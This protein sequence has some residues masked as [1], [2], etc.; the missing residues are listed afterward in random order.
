MS[1]LMQRFVDSFFKGWE[2]GD[3]HLDREENRTIRREANEIAREK[4]RV[5]AQYNQWKMGDT[6][7][8]T[9]A[10]V[11]Q[12][13][14]NAQRLLA[15]AR[16]G[17]GASAGPSPGMLAYINKYG[18]AG[19]END[20]AP[21]NQNVTVEAN[22]GP[23]QLPN[24]GDGDGG[25]DTVDTGAARGGRI[26]RMAKGG[27]AN[28][29]A[30]SFNNAAAAGSRSYLAD[31]QREQPKVSPITRT[32]STQA[33]EGAGTTGPGSGYGDT[34][35]PPVVQPPAPVQP[36]PQAIE[37]IYAPGLPEQGGEY[38]R[39]GGRA[40]RHYAGGGPVT[41]DLSPEAIYSGMT[42]VG[43]DGRTVVLDDRNLK[44]TELLGTRSRPEVLAGV[45]TDEATQTRRIGNVDA[46]VGTR[47]IPRSTYSDQVGPGGGADVDPRQGGE[48]KY[49]PTV[50]PEDDYVNAPT[51][52]PT[53]PPTTVTAPRD[54][55]IKTGPPQW[56]KLR[57]QTRT[58]AYDP[59]KDRMDPH[60]TGP[61]REGRE[62]TGE[63]ALWAQSRPGGTPT[64]DP[65]VPGDKT[66][67]DRTPPG[68]VVY[69]QRVGQAAAQGATSFANRLFHQDRQDANTERGKAA[70]Y[71]GAGA[72]DPKAMQEVFK[73]IDP[74]NKLPMNQKIE[75][76]AQQVYDRFMQQGDQKA[77][78]NAAFEVTQFGIKMSTK[79]GSD[80]MKLIQQGNVAGAVGH[81][82][83]GYNW[84]PN[85]Q[86]AEQRGSNIVLVN[87]QGQVT[88]QFPLDPKMIQNIALGMSTGQLGWDVMQQAGGGGRQTAQAQQPAQP[89]PPAASGAQPSAAPAGPPQ[90]PAAPP[91]TPPATPP[92]APPAAA[93]PPPAAQPAA[94][95]APR[96]P[97]PPA[98]PPAGAPPAAP[99]ASPAPPKPT[100][101]PPATPPA[102]PPAKA[103]AG[104]GA[105]AP[106]TTPSSSTPATQ[107]SGAGASG[108]AIETTPKTA[109]GK[110]QKSA[111]RLE[112]EHWAKNPYNPLP[113][114]DRNRGQIS[115]GAVN[116]ELARMDAEHRKGREERMR[117]AV[118]LGLVKGNDSRMVTKL[119]AGYDKEFEA[120]KKLFLD[121]VEKARARQAKDADTERAESKPR[122]VKLADEGTL[123][124][125]FSKQREATR[126]GSASNKGLKVEY[127]QSPL[128][129]LKTDADREKLDSIAR[130]LWRTNHGLDAKT[131]YEVALASTSIM[132]PT[133]DKDG[134]DKNPV[135]LNRQTGDKA[136]HFRPVRESHRKG[137]VVIQMADGREYIVDPNTYRDI[138]NI[139]QRNWAEYTAQKEKD[140]KRPTGKRAL[141]GVGA[142]IRTVAPFV[143]GLP[144]GV[145]DAAGRAV[146]KL[147]E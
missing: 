142:A 67:P 94:T 122:E 33:Y 120:K 88:Q 2:H 21:V 65:V 139:H 91:A 112:A 37:P 109:S 87:K 10:Y 24:D 71:S 133:K 61:L 81:L 126:D 75:L 43:P 145:G 90:P 114:S 59:E 35:A 129:Y 95:P 117:D 80:A 128:R 50:Y 16:G 6:T 79:H 22:E 52:P 137:H 138:T 123:K 51:P 18:A 46:K 97:V 66:A 3:K 23:I 26:S 147:G 30:T 53:M 131:A 136:T 57:D 92:A 13:N 38:M 143:P 102:A 4:N 105:P 42:V 63:T 135:G 8:R 1:K 7:R 58:E 98:T 141:Q 127:D 115:E 41:Y 111:E 36:A 144:P 100:A 86:T 68:P 49:V 11:N 96:P 32:S 45:K 9:D 5:A 34:A 113:D 55:A 44:E 104:A 19:L 40:V 84:I 146:S 107:Q 134:K 54:G 76:A 89:G 119:L 74:D 28:R 83:A 140:A 73:V 121:R 60:N 12:A 72:P 132:L 56:K 62:S 78:E 82:L 29:F 85:G 124:T 130:N 77:A 48:P 20:S 64:A 103:A 14:A 93:A 15:K 17:T 99:A 110:E 25:G 47:H 106:G 108:G 31:Q 101:T 70:M 69:D 118:K 125:G 27:R 116:S 39:R